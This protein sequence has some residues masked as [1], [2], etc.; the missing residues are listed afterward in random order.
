MLA[1]GQPAWAVD[2][3]AAS[4][5]ALGAGAV[6]EAFEAVVTPGTVVRAVKAT[7]KTEAAALSGTA[8]RAWGT[9][10]EVTAEAMMAGAGKAA[11][12]MEL[13]W[14]PPTV[15]LWVIRMVH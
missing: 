1:R 14:V 11:A 9:A 12:A 2:V 15:W 8:V 6:V 4:A 7:A 3:A 10:A 5:V 13:R